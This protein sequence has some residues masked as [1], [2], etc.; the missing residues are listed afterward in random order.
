MPREDY[1]RFINIFQK[2][3]SKYK[4]LSLETDKNY[5]N[6][7]IKITDSTTKIIDT[8][9]TKTYESGIFIDIFPI[10]RFDDPKVIDTCYKL[11]SFKLLSFSKHKNIV[12]KDS[13]LKDWIRTAFWLLLR[14]V[15]P[16]Y[17]ANKIEKE[18]Q[19]YSRENG[20]YMAFIPSK[21]K[22]KEVFPSGTFDK[23]IDL[24]F[25]NLSLPAPEK[26][27]T[28]L[29]QFYGDYMTLPPEEKRFYSH[30]FHAYKL[31]D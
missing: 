23:T 8:R 2:E 5:F 6:N 22:E 26:F 19:K 20:Q 15:S 27:D 25:E 24:P 1:Q 13:L 9:N 11:E 30:E 7:F 14:P 3:K 31:E 18:I 21:F 12:Y 4:L 28:I 17:F 16:R 10:D 29:T